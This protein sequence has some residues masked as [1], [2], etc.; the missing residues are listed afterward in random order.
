MDKLERTAPDGASKK[1]S[2]LG[3]ALADV[4]QFIETGKPTAELEAILNNLDSRGLGEFVKV[5]YHVIRGLAYYTGVVFEA[6]DLQ[7]RIPRHRR[8]RPLR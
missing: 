2:A 6:F 1:F 5:D 7:G 3:F 4:Q 8:W